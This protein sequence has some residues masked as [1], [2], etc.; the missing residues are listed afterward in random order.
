MSLRAFFTACFV[1][2]ALCLTANS[3]SRAQPQ[4]KPTL[5]GAM[6]N[7]AERIYDFLVDEGLFQ[8]DIGRFEGPQRATAG[9]SIQLKLIEQLQEL[10]RQ[11]KGQ[12]RLERR[13]PQVTVRGEFRFD[14]E[15]R[16]IR[17]VARLYDVNNRELKQFKQPEERISEPNDV[18]KLL[19]VTVDQTPIL[20]SDK[21]NREVLKLADQSFNES[22]MTPRVFV[23]NGTVVLA[24]AE[25]PQGMEI[26]LKTPAGSIPQPVSQERGLAFVDLQPGQEFEIRIRNRAEYDIGVEL[27][28]D[29]V[30]SLVLCENEEFRKSG[31]WVVRAGK[32]ARIKG[33]LQNTTQLRPFVITDLAGGVLSEVGA[34]DLSSLG[35]ITA[36]FYPAWQAD[37]Q[38]PA[39]ERLGERRAI[40]GGHSVEVGT[41]TLPAHFGQTLLGSISVRY[42]REG[43]PNSN[44]TASVR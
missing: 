31:L 21:P 37:T 3:E 19:G 6:G 4:I 17:I 14:Q 29:G 5:D 26:L 38:P 43:L 18:V 28:L 41:A 20:A 8:V 36:A 42:E 35:T 25:S 15:A 12:V 10:T 27:S 7:L 1:V 22:I 33:W 30:N 44:E 13:I 9:V 40:G 23:E 16:I 11:R 24:S 2:G 39:V 32:V 34:S